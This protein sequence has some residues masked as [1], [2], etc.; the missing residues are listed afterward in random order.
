ME[1]YLTFPALE[2]IYERHLKKVASSKQIY[3]VDTYV[4]YIGGRSRN[5]ESLSTYMTNKLKF[6]K[7][8]SI[9]ILIATYDYNTE[10]YFHDLGISYHLIIPK[11]D[12]LPQYFDLLIKMGYS[13]TYVANLSDNWTDFL[14]AQRGQLVEDSL[15]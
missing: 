9:D 8:N 3:V 14:R 4:E 5:K 11:Q 2:H 6:A 12:K 1:V 10:K 15:V 7:E 13:K